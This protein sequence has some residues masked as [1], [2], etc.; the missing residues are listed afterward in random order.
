MSAEIIKT[1]FENRCITCANMDDDVYESTMMKITE[2]LG[3]FDDN[4][5]SGKAN[6][7][8]EKMKTSSYLMEDIFVPDSVCDYDSGLWVLCSWGCG[9]WQKS[10]KR[11]DAYKETFFR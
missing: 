5:P 6:M 10:S 1:R 3:G 7:Y 11:E 4:A 8:E 9:R 2:R